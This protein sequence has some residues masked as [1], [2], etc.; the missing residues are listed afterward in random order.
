MPLPPDSVDK[1]IMFSV[2]P[3]SPS[4]AFIRLFVQT[5]CYH[6]ISWTILIKLS[7]NIQ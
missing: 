6:N 7:G 3:T 4:N 5:D 2:C 1:G